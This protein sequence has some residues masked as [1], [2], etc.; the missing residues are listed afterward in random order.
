MCLSVASMF[1]EML[2]FQGHR[3][4]NS[5]SVVHLFLFTVKSFVENILLEQFCGKGATIQS[6]TLS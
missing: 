4:N 3:Y 6:S 5:F 1:L 2:A